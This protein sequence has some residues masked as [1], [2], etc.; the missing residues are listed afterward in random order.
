M[1]R[2]FVFL[3]LLGVLTPVWAGPPP[4]TYT[5]I[6]GPFTLPSQPL[7][8]VTA[9]ARALLCLSFTNFDDAVTQ[10]IAYQWNVSADN[11][12]T[13]APWFGATIVGG[14]HFDRLG[15][16]ITEFCS[17]AP[18]RIQGPGRIQLTGTLTSPANIE[19]TITFG[20]SP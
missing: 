7:A 4:D 11:E 19:L 12:V 20:E 15:N 5:V 16:P 18:P 10:R 8:Q 17:A 13:W 14:P 6:P 3:I 9:G 1:R 2:A